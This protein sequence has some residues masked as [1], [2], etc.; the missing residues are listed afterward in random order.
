[1]HGELIP[2]GAKNEALQILCATLLTPETVEVYNLPDILDVNNLIKL[3]RD[4]GVETTKIGEGSYRFKAEN[5]DLDYL[6][7]P[8]FLKQ[9]A[10]L[11]GSVMIL[12]PF[13]YALFGNSKTR[14]RIFLYSPKTNL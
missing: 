7:T 4:L 11:R 14:S 2:Q 6:H 1:M 3:L 13:R 8:Q 12:G 5:I 9:S 10:A